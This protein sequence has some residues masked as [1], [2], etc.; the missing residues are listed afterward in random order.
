MSFTE[1][2]RVFAFNGCRWSWIL[3][4]AALGIGLAMLLRWQQ[5][6]TLHPWPLRPFLMMAVMVGLTEEIVFRGYFL[7]RFL[8]W[9]PPLTA[10]ALSALLHTAYKIALFISTSPAD[11]L[12]FLGSLT[13]GAGLLL[14]YW[15]KASASIWPCV[16]FHSL[17]DLWVYG[18]RATP[19]WV[20]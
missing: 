20:W 16:V 17:F 3:Y 12:L 2:R 11:E 18:D 10:I 6:H 13:F 1:S 14:G 8:E 15:R 5:T 9:Q 19:W 7:G 4:G